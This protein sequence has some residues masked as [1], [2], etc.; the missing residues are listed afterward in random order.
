MSKNLGIFVA[1]RRLHRGGLHHGRQFRRPNLPSDLPAGVLVENEAQ[2]LGMDHLDRLG[3]FIF[4]L[5]S[6]PHGAR[7]RPVGGTGLFAQHER[8]HTHHETCTARHPHTPQCFLPPT[9]KLP[10]HS[11][12][13]Y[14]ASAQSSISL[15]L[16]LK[17]RYTSLES[18]IVAFLRRKLTQ[19]NSVHPF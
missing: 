12:L 7:G 17:A 9:H 10:L 5:P 11:T 15:M 19:G 2:P 4:G 18:Y 6:R 14:S 16:P 13:P 3:I 8:G 1:E